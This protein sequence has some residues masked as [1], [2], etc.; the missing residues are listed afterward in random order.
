MDRTDELLAEIKLEFPR[1]RVV[2]KR[3]DRLSKLIDRV[4]RVVTFGGQRDYLTH[5]YTVL[6]H[7]LYTPDGW[8]RSDDLD[9]VITLRH[10]RVHL[11]QLRRYTPP[12]MVFLYIFPFAPL[13]LAY[14]R[15]RIEWEAYTETIRATAEL[16]GLEAAQSPRLRKHIIKQFTS[17]S[18]GW[19]WP[20]ERQVERWYDE[21]LARITAE[22]SGR[23]LDATTMDREG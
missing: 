11:R 14:G 6:F 3:D 18:Y 12:G 23:P 9:R 22:V 19:M 1:F 20:F 21:A 16:R 13:G 5:Y 15:A 17:G 10:E 4:L 7:T 8:E 2:S